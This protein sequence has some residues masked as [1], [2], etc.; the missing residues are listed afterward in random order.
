MKKNENSPLLPEKIA[1]NEE[2]QKQKSRSLWRKASQGKN[3]RSGLCAL[4]WIA[5]ILLCIMIVDVGVLLTQLQLKTLTLQWLFDTQLSI[6]RFEQLPILI[7]LIKTVF[8][9]LAMFFRWLYYPT[10]AVIL[11]IIVLLASDAFRLD[12]FTQKELLDNELDKANIFNILPLMFSVLES[13]CL[14]SVYEDSKEKEAAVNLDKE[15]GIQ[16]P[17]HISFSKMLRVLRPYF[18]PHGLG[19]RIR[20]CST[21]VLLGASKIANIVSPLFMAN[22]TNA[23]IEKDVS[24]AL[25]SVS[26]YCILVLVSSILKELQSVIYLKVKQTAYVEI[27]T[28]TYEH[29]HSLSLDWHLKKVIS[30]FK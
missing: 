11:S 8:L 14:G 29:L 4:G 12:A 18:W 26:I 19:N 7:T 25:A 30:P 3:K 28:L 16:K 20:A 24:K 10:Q 15:P 5:T 21:Y 13:V 2:M 23:L 27:A 9:F 22:A 17:N 6:W 1:H